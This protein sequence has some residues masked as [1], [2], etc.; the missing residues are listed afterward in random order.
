MLSSRKHKIKLNSTE[1]DEE[2]TIDS[3]NDLIRAVRKELTCSLRDLMQ[4]GLL[5]VNRGTSLVPFGCFVVRSKETQN[6]MHVWD[7]IMK[8]YE[9]KVSLLI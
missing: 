8:Y 2:Q 5:E 1:S 7:L 9:M 6:Q 4:H 3:P